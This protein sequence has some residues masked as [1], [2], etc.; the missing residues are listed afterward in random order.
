MTLL[1]TF[2]HAPTRLVTHAVIRLRYLPCLRLLLLP[3]PPHPGE[4]VV[5]TRS[6][7]PLGRSIRLFT[8]A[9][10]DVY[11]LHRCWTLPVDAYDSHV[12]VVGLTVNDYRHLRFTTLPIYYA[13]CC[14]FPIAYIRWYAFTPTYGL[15]IYPRFLRCPV[16]HL[17]GW[18]YA[19]WFAFV[20]ATLRFIC[21]AFAFTRTVVTTVVTPR[22][23]LIYHGL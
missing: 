14:Y 1:L 23:L 12:P 3:C 20:Y 7:L 4:T 2:P 11:S 17:P 15:F 22:L 13:V 19:V 5:A 10:T 21:R 16:Y 9:F 6:L 18:L 8:H